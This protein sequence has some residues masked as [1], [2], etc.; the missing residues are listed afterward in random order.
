L[1]ECSVA[2]LEIGTTVYAKNL[3]MPAGC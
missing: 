1:I 3:V 2:D